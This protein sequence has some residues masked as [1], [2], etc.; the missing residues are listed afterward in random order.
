MRPTK[1]V[2]TM[3]CNHR[4]WEYHFARVFVPEVRALVD[5]LETRLLPT[6]TNIKAE[7]DRKGDEEWKRLCALPGDGSDDMADLAEQAFDAGLAHYQTMIG[8]R[9]GLLNLFSVA[10]FH[11][12]E[13][14]VMLFHRVEVLKPGEGNNTKLLK[15]STFRERLQTYGVDITSLA[16]W[17]TLEELGLVANAVKHAEGDSSAKLR[18]VRPDLFEAPELAGFDFVGLKSSVRVFTPLTGDDIYVSLQDLK[19]YADAV[20]RFWTELT[21]ALAQA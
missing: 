9:Q 15:H 18:T 5:T 2:R 10:L 1:R 4:F 3:V 6:F 16:S 19:R 14:H 7:A 20:V 11:L 13:Q 8:L 21:D 17:T 12:Y